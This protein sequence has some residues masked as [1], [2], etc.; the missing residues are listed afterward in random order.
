MKLYGYWRSSAAYR[1]RIALNVKGL[2]YE[3]QSVHLVKDG[4]Q[5]HTPGYRE[6]NPQSLVPT[7]LLDDGSVLTQSMA[8][9][10]F[11]E[12]QFAE[13]A[14]LPK[15]ATARAI[16]RSMCQIIV[17]DIHPIDNLR[18]LQYLKNELRVS[19][20]QK[21]AWYGHWIADGFQALETLVARY[22]G[23]YCF[24]DTVSLADVC[25]VPQIYN[26]RRFNISLEAFPHLAGIESNCQ[27]IRAFRE[28]APEVQPDAEQ[29]RKD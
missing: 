6:K 13:P 1:V 7:L 3:Q 10:E 12:E 16:V 23:E 9:M 27:K 29:T 24:G 15:N 19:D 14:L 8:I 4:G 21:A 5:Q 22:R 11:L 28:A 20:E 26:A 2:S 18:V 25:L 17:S